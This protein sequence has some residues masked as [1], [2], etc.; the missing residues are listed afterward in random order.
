MVGS[1]NRSYIMT[2][3][4]GECHGYMTPQP[5]DH[6][7]AERA[8]PALLSVFPPGRQREELL[9]PYFSILQ[10]W[11]PAAEIEMKVDD[12]G[13]ELNG[14]GN[15]GVKGNVKFTVKR[16]DTITVTTDTSTFCRFRKDNWQ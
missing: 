8:N 14:S 5:W 6:A 1:Y 11:L 15:I 7:Q 10:P 13:N 16:V 9:S 4:L 2:S 12:S 3:F